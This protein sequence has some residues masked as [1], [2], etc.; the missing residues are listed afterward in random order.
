M[1]TFENL[2]NHNITLTNRNKCIVTGVKDVPSSDEEH[3]QIA[4]NS[5]KL[6]I[7]GYNLKISSLDLEQGKLEF[8][9][10]VSQLTYARQKHN[11]LKNRREIDLP[12]IH[13]EK[14]VEKR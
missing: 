3:I 14:Y 13:V 9:G 5:D 7:K 12:K 8:T 1:A 2:K 11:F 4:T 10:E 6:C